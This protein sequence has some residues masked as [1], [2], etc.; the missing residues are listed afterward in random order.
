MSGDKIG[1][2]AEDTGHL[3]PGAYFPNPYLFLFEFDELQNFTSNRQ[4]TSCSARIFRY[5]SRL[6]SSNITVNRLWSFEYS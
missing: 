5:L 1:L 3:I 4:R 2:F 6:A